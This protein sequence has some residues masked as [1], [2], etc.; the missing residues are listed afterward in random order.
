MFCPE[1][2]KLLKPIYDLTRKGR[3]FLWG[4]EQWDAFE[5]SKNRMQRCPVLSMP[6]RK[7][8]FILYSDTNKTATGSVFYQFQDGKPRLIAYTSKRMPDAA[9]N[10]SITELEMSGLAINIANF[11]HLLR[12][13]DCDA[14]VGHLAITHIMKSKM[15]PATNRIK[16]LLQ[17]L[18]SYSFNLY[19][20]KGK[21]M[22]LSDF[23]SRQL[24]DKGDPHQIIPIS[25][26]MK[27]MLKENYQNNAEAI[28]MVQTRSQSKKAPVVKKSANSS[29]TRN[30]S[31]TEVQEIKSIIIDDTQTAPDLQK[32]DS[33]NE[34]NI[35]I[36]TKCPQINQ[37]YAQLVMRP[38]PRPP[39]PVKP[40][41]CTEIGPSLDSEESS[42][43]QEGIITEMYEGP[44]KSYLEQPQELTDLVDSTKLI[45][46]YL[47]KQVDIDKIL[48]IIKKKVLKGTRLPLTIK[49]IQ[50]GYLNSL[51]FKG[52]YGYMAQ[53]KLPS[54]KNSIC[55][56]LTLSQNY[57]LLDQLLFKLITVLGKE[58]ALL[59]I[60]EM[61]TD[62]IISLYHDT[63]FAGHQG[64]IKTYLTI[65]SKFFIPNLMHYLRA[66]LKACHICQL[67]RNDKP[68]SRQ[69]ETRI[70]LNYRPM[71]RLSMDLKVMPRSQ[72]GHQ[73]ILCIIDEVTNYLVSAPLYQARSE[74]IG[75]ALI[76]NDTSKFGTPAYIIMDQDSTF[77]SSLMNYLFKALGIKIKTVGPY[78]HKSLQVEHGI[79]SLS[80][81]LTKHLTGQGQTWHKFLLLATFAYNMF[82]SPKLGNYSPFELTLGR[83]PRILLNLETNPDTRVSGTYKDY[84]TL[85]T[86]RLKYLQNMLQNV[87][88]KCVVLINKDREY[89]QYSPG[90]LVYLNSPLT[91]QLRTN[92]RKV[93]IKFVGPLVVYRIVDPHNYLL[94]TID[95]QLIRG[96]FEHE[97]LK[98]AV[99][100]TNQGNVKTLSALK[101]A[102][103]LEITPHNKLTGKIY[104]S[105]DQ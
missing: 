42:P 15:A 77:M 32:I 25:F 79:K 71:P 94:M 82:H 50:A 59:A 43:H 91:T 93:S 18:S 66:F 84:Q 44:D 46:K 33:Q 1:L 72:K 56:V 57:I 31:N 51:F 65:S 83:E 30:S 24:G 55:K 6:D 75:E 54:K 70:N 23:L 74:E 35:K 2:Q 49:E 17:V 37:N 19:Y 20:I 80:Y 52:L 16:R 45:L 73:Y 86:K 69:L 5:E 96:L 28:F 90:N 68:P 3:P 100:N 14:V 10:Y 58:K 81:I 85:L 61:C 89:F 22:V 87:K 39:D 76:E 34:A 41:V 8:R 48:N 38:P 99:I 63:L 62:K 102:M 98:P 60:P 97:R 4:K 105:Q 103:N 78:S 67:N 21:D 64:V 101:K 13:L 47:P 9:K 53:N 88:S 27:E 95:G 29:N 7:G 26:N 36:P 12:K 104:I 11:S 40:K 92:S